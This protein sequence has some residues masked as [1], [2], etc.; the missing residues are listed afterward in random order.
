MDLAVFKT[1]INHVM[2]YV[3][4]VNASKTSLT[5]LESLHDNFVENQSLVV[6]G[7]FRLRVSRDVASIFYFCNKLWCKFLDN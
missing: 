4:V 5:A 7:E 1:C 6:Q 3:T 2:E